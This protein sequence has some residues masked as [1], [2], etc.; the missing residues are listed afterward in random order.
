MFLFHIFYS[1]K[2]VS[3][4]CKFLFTFEMNH[5]NLKF[6]NLESNFWNS[7]FFRK[8]NEKQR[9][10]ILRALRIIFFPFFVCFL[11]E[12][13]IPRIAFEIYWP[14]I[15]LA[16]WQKTRLNEKNER[17]RKMLQFTEC[18]HLKVLRWWQQ[19]SKSFTY[20]VFHYTS[21]PVPPFC[22]FLAGM[23]ADPMKHGSV[24]ICNGKH[25]KVFF[26]IFLS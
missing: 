2:I 17:K 20:F 25:G 14:L 22:E 26:L 9:K 1:T 13:R 19:I 24:A 23:L 3:L 12:L 6:A 11:E 15:L 5:K 8:K 7:Q 21:C 10:T 18:N 16:D 4:Y